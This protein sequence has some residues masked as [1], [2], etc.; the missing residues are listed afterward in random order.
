VTD[1]MFLKR[2]LISHSESPYIQ[3]FRYCVLGAI[4]FFLDAS[5]LFLITESGL[6]YMYSS[7]I[8][9]VIVVFVHLWISKK[10]IF[11]SCAMPQRT[12]TACYIGISVIGLILTELFMFMFTGLFGVYYIFSKVITT[13]IVLAWNFSARKFW[14]YRV[15]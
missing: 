7:A 10:F 12:E 11:T 5:L 13:F 4:T 3:F 8:S 2:L 14:L 15:R 9:F 6:N 1:A